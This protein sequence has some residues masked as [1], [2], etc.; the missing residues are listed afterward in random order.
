MN[1]G[2]FPQLRMPRLQGQVSKVGTEIAGKPN[3]ADGTRA[4]N[5]GLWD[6]YLPA[7][8]V[9]TMVKMGWDKTT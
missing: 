8:C 2:T 4:G 6:S 1:T 7:D 9:S 5:V 3:G